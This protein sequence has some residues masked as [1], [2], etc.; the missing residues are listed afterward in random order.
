MIVMDWLTAAFERTW[1]YVATIIIGVMYGFGGLVH[2]GNI[3]GFGEMTWAESPLSW[4]LGDVFWGILDIVAVV[5]I[6]LKAP[7][8]VLAVT[9]AALSQIVVYGIWPERFALTDEHLSVLR[10]MV[11]FN[12]SVLIILGCLVWLAS[13]KSGT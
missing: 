8:G 7:V 2:V 12:T 9:L 3:L 13:S 4:K 11:F 10:G 1:F 5:G 6:I